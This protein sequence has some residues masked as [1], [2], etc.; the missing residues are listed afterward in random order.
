MAESTTAAA[1]AA[2]AALYPLLTSL[3]TL[4][5]ASRPACRQART[6]A[7]LRGVAVGWL[8]ACGRHTL[9]GVLRALGQVEGDW[10]ATYRLFGAPRVDFAEAG[11]RLLAGTLPLSDAATP[12]LV[13]LDATLVPRHSRT[14]PGTGWFRAPG[15]A[16]FRRGLCRAQRFVGLHWVALPSR[17]GYSRAVPL[18]W[19]A[20]FSP[21]AVPAPGHPPEKEWAAGRDALAWL[22]QGLDGAK[23]ARQRIL[24][25][26]DGSYATKD[27][28]AALPDRVDLVARCAKNRALFR[29]PPPRAGKG[30][31]RKYGERA[32]RPDAWLAE[33]A[34]WRR[35]QAVVRGRTIPLT[36]RAEGPF[37][38]K[39]A[40][41]RPVFL[42]VVKGIAKRS[43]AHKRREPAYWLAT[44]VRGE[45]GAWRLPWPARDLLAWAWQRWEVE[46]AHREQKTSFGLGEAQCWGPRSA[47]A[48]VQFAG[49]VYGVTVLAGLRAWGQGPAPAGATRPRWWRG[50]GRWS[51][52]QLLQAIRAEL[53]D[54][55][56]FRPVWTG[57]GGNWWEIGDWWAAQTNALLAADRT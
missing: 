15:T 54:L 34:G 18:R 24:A 31:P 4:V 29:L 8:L 56:D 11:A 47:V 23:R 30:R 9:T 14:M 55:G 13:A 57:T 33:R 19:L 43:K 42:L 27:L 40:A 3:V 49:W 32:K 39:G 5:E 26:G 1:P 12:Y 46:V 44:A 50:G 38:V 48:S 16:P 22:R 35:S 10:A 52:G 41:E 7:R 25:L 2:P 51:I 45:D 37:V 21:S 28:L 17:E 53:W 6:H 36:W 20:A